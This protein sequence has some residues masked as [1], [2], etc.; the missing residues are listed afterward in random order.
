MHLQCELHGTINPENS[1]S[2]KAV[3]RLVVI[4]PF[5][6]SAGKPGNRKPSVFS[7]D[8]LKSHIRDFFIRHCFLY[9]Y[10]IFLSSKRASELNA[11][12]ASLFMSVKIIDLIL[13]CDSTSLSIKASMKVTVPEACKFL[14]CR[15]GWLI[16]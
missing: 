7:H 14:F 10:T 1:V 9:F 4:S 5:L 11:I 3:K 6:K 13:V 12:E 2:R 8:A 15:C 16:G